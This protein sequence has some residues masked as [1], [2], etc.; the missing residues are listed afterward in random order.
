VAEE[1]ADQGYH[2][3]DSKF[4]NSLS[5]KAKKKENLNLTFKA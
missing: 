2:Q 5:Y 1:S 4:H 3:L